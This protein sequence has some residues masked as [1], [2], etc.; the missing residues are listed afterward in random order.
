MTIR[1][2]YQTTDPL[3]TLTCGMYK[4]EI[5]ACREFDSIIDGTGLFTIAREVLATPMDTDDWRLAK[6][7]RLDRALMPTHLAI[8]RGW[9]LGAI[10][11]EV[12][13]SQV[14]AGPPMAQ[15]RDYRRSWLQ[16]D[17]RQAFRISFAFLFPYRPAGGGMAYSLMHSDRVGGAYIKDGELVL[18]C[19]GSIIAALDINGEKHRFYDVNFGRKRFS[20]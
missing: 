9:Q 5:D 4:T 8:D 20:R 16:I 13:R 14:K 15:A 6:R 3:G 11:V 12:K 18:N 17:S 7:G 2:N 10:G 1:L 19:G